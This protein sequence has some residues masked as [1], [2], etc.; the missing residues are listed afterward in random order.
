MILPSAIFHTQK[1]SSCEIVR[2]ILFTDL[3]VFPVKTSLG[4]IMC[5]LQK[6]F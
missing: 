6:Q 3:A 1:K 2:L 5:K 4:S